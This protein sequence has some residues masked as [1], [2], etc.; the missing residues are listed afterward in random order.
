MDAFLILQRKFRSI[1]RF[2]KTAWD[3]FSEVKRKIETGEAPFEPPPFDP[4]YD[5]TEPPFTE[6]WTEADEFQNVV[7]QAA[8]TLLHSALK[9]YLDDFL[10]R[11]GLTATAEKYFSRRR[12]DKTKKGESW[13][14]RY[15]AFLSDA[16]GVDWANSVVSAEQI[17]EINLAR[18]DLQHG[19]SAYNLSRY[20]TELHKLKF[21]S[22]LFVGD[23]EKRHPTFTG[24]ISVTR[25]TFHAAVERIEEFCRFVESYSRLVYSGGEMP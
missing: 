2:H 20:R 18:N 24:E 16:Y 12:N 8:I 10:E 1:Q 9:D 7:G 5:D 6:E 15:L 4:E 14:H 25:E 21:P 13:F 3:S 23:F 17:E 11:D 19:Q 22:G